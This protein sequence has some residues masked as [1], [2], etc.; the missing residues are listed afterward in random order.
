MTG[1]GPSLPTHLPIRVLTRHGRSPGALLGLTVTFLP[2][3]PARPTLLRWLFLRTLCALSAL[4]PTHMLSRHKDQRSDGFS[5]SPAAL[6]GGVGKVLSS[7]IP[8]SAA[9][10]FTLDTAAT[11]P[12]SLPLPLAPW[13]LLWSRELVYASLPQPCVLPLG[14]SPPAAASGEK[15][16]PF[17]PSLHPS[18]S[19]LS[20][21]PPSPLSLP[22]ASSQSSF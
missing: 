3:L 11:P 20:S 18:L 16:P 9:P 8:P 6:G 22:G 2:E 14:G 13:F 21:L 4:L 19:L 15:Q 17:P 12:P 1:W 7:A 5:L 10:S